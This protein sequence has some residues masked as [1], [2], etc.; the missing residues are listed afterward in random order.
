MTK[1]TYNNPTKAK[2]IEKGKV[3]CLNRNQPSQNSKY[4]K[5]IFKF[6]SSHSGI[7]V[8]NIQTGHGE[9]IPGVSK[10]RKKL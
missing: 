8:A 3:K 9:Q 2:Y 7:Q 6:P 4:T 1:P 5:L 10:E